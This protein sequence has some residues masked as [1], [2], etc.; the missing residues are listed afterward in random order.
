LLSVNR[1]GER[2]NHRRDREGTR[3][4]ERVHRR[5]MLQAARISFAMKEI[6]RCRI[7]GQLWWAMTFRIGVRR[8]PALDGLRAVSIALVVLAHAA[9]TRHVEILSPLVLF[10]DLG[11]LGVCVFF[12]IS[13]FL[14]TKLLLDEHD[15]ERGI[16]LAA[17][18]ERRAFRILPSAGAYLAALATV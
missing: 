9:G 7:T 11:N 16:D 15:R 14:I 2:G 12:V 5:S 1:A 4:T 8:I 6:P 10:G 13:G 17:F 3:P 18:Y